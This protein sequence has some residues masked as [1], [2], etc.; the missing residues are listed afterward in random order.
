VRVT[1]AVPWSGMLLLGTTEDPFDGDPASVA[2]EPGD[3]T[4]ILREAAHALDSQIL[5]P[6]RVL[7]AYA[8][9]RVLPEGEGEVASARRETVF[10]RGPA[11]M[12]SVAGGKLTTY[13]R[14]ALEVLDRLRAELGVHRLDRRPWPLPGAT[15]LASVALPNEL[16]PDVREHLLHLYGSLAP[17]V[18]ATA[19]EEPALLERISPDGPDLAAQVGYAAT[20]E[21]ARNVDDVVRRRTTLFYR[22]LSGEDV[23]TRVSELLRENG[24]Q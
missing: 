20:R 4:Q 19:R 5:D 2:A 15:G 8:G 9:L 7:A 16:D 22:G 21:W 23:A 13:R 24:S 3:V 12:L 18:V 6:G 17:E 10:T 1:F 14:I 11:G